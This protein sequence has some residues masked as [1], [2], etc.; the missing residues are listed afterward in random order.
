MNKFFFKF[1]RFL[2][3][4]HLKNLLGC[5]RGISSFCPKKFFR[6][7]LAERQNLFGSICRKLPQFRLRT[8]FKIASIFILARVAGELMA[9]PVFALSYV[10]PTTVDVPAAS[11]NLQNQI[12]ADNQQIAALNKQIA[13]YQA[14]LKQAGSDKK[15]LQ[16]ALKTLD[17]KREEVETQVAATQSQIN[18][19]QL[20]V[21][22]LDGQ[23]QDTK[24]T[25]V[26][27]QSSLSKDLEEIQQS[28]GQ[29]AIFQLFS[30][31]S[32]SGFWQNVDEATQV[33]DAVRQKTQ[34]L[35]AAETLLADTQ[36]AVQRKEQTLSAQN[37]SLVSQRQ[38]LNATVQSKNQLLAET[39]NKESTYQKLL[40]QAEA[41][42]ESFSK[43]TQHAGGDQLLGNQTVCDAW[44]CYYNQRDSAWGG[45]A[46]DGT[47]YTMAGDGCLVT[48]MAMV[49]TH[50]GYRDVTPATINSNPTNFAV[51]YPSYLL[52]SINV[53]GVTATRKTAAIDATLAT[54]N[55]VVI[56][57]NVYGGTHFV[58]LV[59][60]SGGN[61]I[62]RDPYVPSGKDI[63]FAAFYN[64]GEIYSITNVVISS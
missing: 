58:V 3:G 56:G 2:A 20:Q 57:M 27:Y 51:Y 14:E 43:F 48:A 7:A 6:S 54:G 50:Y 31:G 12:S 55:P 34:Q 9:F 36:S 4:T 44:G 5:N 30:A 40:A 8:I 45:D 23:I 59:S 63:N 1:T 18:S 22:Q 15:T 32:L 21:Q 37:K 29:P 61:Y 60:G 10:A 42:V 46:L 38:S 52:N 28:D 19:T 53:D 47:A 17:L 25:I 11:S 24:Q 39:K 16:T 13:Q 62:M 64:L 26:Q 35:Q 41:Q 33:Q 49:M